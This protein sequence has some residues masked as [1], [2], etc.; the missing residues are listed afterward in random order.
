[1]SGSGSHEAK[2]TSTSHLNKFYVTFDEIKSHHYD[3]LSSGAPVEQM[4]F[5]EVDY[6]EELVAVMDWSKKM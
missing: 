3:G 2:N 1:M 4:E 6:W 5:E